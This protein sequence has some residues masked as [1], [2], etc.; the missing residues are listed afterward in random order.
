VSLD[1]AALP[2]LSALAAD[3]PLGVE[4]L[5]NHTAEILA[6]YR[7]K[8]LHGK[9]L[10]AAISR[11]SR[12]LRPLDPAV[13]ELLHSKPLFPRTKCTG[14]VANFRGIRAGKPTR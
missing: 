4:N 1:R 11:H 6:H 8:G 9:E 7:A 14:G 2:H 3:G 13:S 12:L 5:V 10:R